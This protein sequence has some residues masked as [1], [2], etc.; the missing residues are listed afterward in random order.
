M[1]GGIIGGDRVLRLVVDGF[2]VACE[3]RRFGVTLGVGS[4]GCWLLLVI[5]G[6][7]VVLEVV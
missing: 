5:W 4:G 3:G 2:L 6:S 7:G 1:V